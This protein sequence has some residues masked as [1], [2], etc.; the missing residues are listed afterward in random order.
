MCGSAVR[1][2]TVFIAAVG[3]ALAAP[4]SGTGQAV[5]GGEWRDDVSTFIR[6]VV[7]AGLTPGLGVA[8]AAGDRVAW[9]QGFGTADGRTG[10]QVTPATPFYIASSTK[11]LTAT[12]AVLAAHVGELDLDA[13]MVRYLPNLRL[14]EGV[15]PSSIRV[16]DLLTL[17]HGLAGGG[18]VV[19]RTAFTGEFTRDQLLEL[20]QYHEPTGRRGAF[21][22]NNLGYNLLGMVLEAAYGGEGWKEIVERLVLEPL[23]MSS[24]SA[25]ASHFH[26][27]ELAL[28]HSLGPDGFGRLP[29]MKT[30]ANLH[31]A[32]GHFATATDLARYLAAHQS[33]GWLEG[34]SV[35]PAAPLESTHRRHVVQDRRFGPYH[36]FGWGLGWDLGTYEGDTLVHR[37]GGFAGYRSHM[38]FMPEHDLAVVVLVN[39]DGPASPAA[40]LVATY[41]YDRL[42]GKADLEDRYAERL[43]S[44]RATAEESRTDIAEHLRER[45]GR[46]A[47]LPRPLEAYAGIYE[48]AL[49]GR[50]E[51]RVVAGGLEMWIGVLHSRAEVFDAAE[52]LLRVELA[53]S[54]NVAEFAFEGEGPATSVTLNGIE[55]GRVERP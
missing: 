29:L 18:P 44:L 22:Y 9:S 55:F 14:P 17:T 19:L 5:I 1:G 26:P 41:V 53:G 31:A 34:Q 13:P 10:R 37:F 46:R 39:G 33:E 24:T 2:A 27:D 32:G 21:D 30:D 23:G 51:W 28:P 49:L 20:L 40:D 50:M 16:R 47:P 3:F 43:E 4:T 54:G 12:A 15:D 52:N 6:Q 25:Y 42:L 36:R 38:S 45:A 48:S 7:D 11:S 35:L 8:V